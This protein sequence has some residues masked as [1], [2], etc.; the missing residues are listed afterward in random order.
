MS[1]LKNVINALDPAPDKK[2]EITLAV[3]LLS[4]LANQKSNIQESF[5]KEQ[6]RS[7]GT[8]ENPSIPITNTLAW[9]T[10][11]R[12]YVKSDA[13]QLVEK[14][15]DAVRKFINGGSDEIVSGIGDLLTAG[16][17]IILGSGS[18][19]EANMHSY[20]IVVEGFSIVRF[21]LCAWQRRIE[22][23]GF[24]SLIENAMTMTA[25][26]SS[27]DV[28]KITFNTFLQAYKIQL[29]RMEIPESE[30]IQ[31]I[32]K[33]KEV[34]E[35]LRDPSSVTAMVGASHAPQFNHP[36]IVTFF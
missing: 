27:V 2:K 18:G 35:L 25:V 13:A 6:L 11:T 33:A 14:V 24:T 16:L 8:P 4:E 10:E 36:G 9:H 1:A 23:T 17:E 34:F 3:E 12:A 29:E 15:T 5:L 32:K 7:A 20:F 19:M 22:V 30:L 26:K 21:D 31:Y 28:D